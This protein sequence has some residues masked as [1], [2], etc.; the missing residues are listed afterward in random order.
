MPTSLRRGSDPGTT[1]ASFRD[2]PYTYQQHQRLRELRIVFLGTSLEELT[3]FP[4]QQTS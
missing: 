4:G 1:D 3:S 2:N